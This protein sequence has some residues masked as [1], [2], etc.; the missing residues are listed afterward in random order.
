M[1]TVHSCAFHGLD[2]R[3][4]SITSEVLNAVPS[5]EF[6][7]QNLHAFGLNCF[8]L[9]PMQ[10]SHEMFKGCKTLR[11]ISLLSCNLVSVPNLEYISN[12]LEI[13][14]LVNNKITSLSSMYYIYLI[15]LKILNLYRNHL[16]QVNTGLLYL[17]KIRVINLDSNSLLH[18]D[19]RF[20]N[21]RQGPTT[22]ILPHSTWNC[23][24]NWDWLGGGCLRN[25]TGEY[26]WQSRNSSKLILDGLNKLSCQ[27][28]E[29]RQGERL[30]PQAILKSYT[31]SCCFGNVDNGAV[32][33]RR[34]AWTSEY[35]VRKS[36]ICP[37]FNVCTCQS[38]TNVFQTCV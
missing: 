30:I 23:S 36:P 37:K 29:K 25:K 11:D 33:P 20:N 28:L 4:L 21:S 10:L 13:L 38:S 16:L 17:P 9:C 35:R 19:L 2:L 7:G 18:I 32:T 24:M 14:I 3:Q 31:T 12:T 5:L 6:V 22:I 34:V 8:N 15:K 26:T 27:F 1:S